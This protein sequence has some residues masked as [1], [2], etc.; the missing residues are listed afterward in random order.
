VSTCN[1]AL[2]PGQQLESIRPKDEGA[3]RKF[4]FLNHASD[5]NVYVT[6][7]CVDLRELHLL[8]TVAMTAVQEQLGERKPVFAYEFLNKPRA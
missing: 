3:C 7:N 6:A 1:I 2:M 4:A 5:G 8:L